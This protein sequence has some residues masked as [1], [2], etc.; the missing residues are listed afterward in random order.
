MSTTTIVVLGAT[1]Y[2]GALIVDALARRGRQPLLAARDAGK[3]ADLAAQ[4]PPFG[5]QVVDATDV[6]AVRSLLSPGDVLV[7]TVGPFEKLGWAAAE[8]AVDAGAHYVDTTGEVGFVREL[9]RRHHDRAVAGG[10]TMLPAFGYDYV[11]GMLAGALALERAGATAAAVRIGYFALGS[12]RNGI[13]R[14]TRATMRDGLLLPT[15]VR[16]EG[17]LREERTAGRTEKF[18]V[19]GD[20]RTGI[21]VSGTEPLFLAEAYRHVRTI[22]DYNGWFSHTAPVLPAVTRVASAVAETSVGRRL[23]DKL[24]GSGGGDSPGPD[25]RERVKTRTHVVARVTDAHETRL[26]ESHVEGP[27]PYSLTAELIASAAGSLLDGPADAV[28]VVG[29]LQAFGLAGLEQMCRD[30]GLTEVLP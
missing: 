29:P 25:A 18:D 15:V 7:T 2:T 27:N 22:E 3:L 23:V 8:A 24:A 6:A 1:G 26:A 4:H 21:L 30:V 20:A 19:R 17:L 13:S 14:G 28:G 12:L 5:T 16:R 11:P 9:Q 10:V